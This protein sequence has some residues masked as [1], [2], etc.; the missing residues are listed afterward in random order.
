MVERPRSPDGAAD[1]V[2]R[3][4]P[5]SAQAETKAPP[6]TTPQPQP[7]EPKTRRG[8]LVTSGPGV[9][10]P[11]LIRPPS[12]RYPPAAL[13]LGR[14]G[15]V[16]VRVLVDENGKPTE[17]RQVGPEVGMGFDKSALRAAQVAV[18]KPA[19]KNGVKV[20]MWFDLVVQ[21]EP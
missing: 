2:T 13:R 1:L 18:W 16:R 20:K 12:P 9:V 14:T 5:P 7:R 15:V 19:T 3:V 8:D 21:F 11:Q 17:I 4:P 6:K 10:P